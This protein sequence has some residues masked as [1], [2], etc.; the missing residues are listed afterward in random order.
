M[1]Y[2]IH[3]DGPPLILLHGGMGHTGYWENQIPVLS[4]QYKVIAVD[5]RGHGRSTFSGQ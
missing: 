2:E 3:G 5:S 1:Y 4:R